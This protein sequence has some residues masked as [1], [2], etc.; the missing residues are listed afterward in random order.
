MEDIAPKLFENIKKEFESRFSGSSKIKELYKR[1]KSG[2]ATYKDAHEFAIETGKI[3]SFALKKN[4]RSSEL[5]DGRMYYN[6]ADR[7][8]RLMLKNNYELITEVSAIVQ[9]TLNKAANIGIKAIKPEFNTDRAQGIIDIVSGKDKYDD[10]AYMFDEPITNFSQSI[11]DDSVRTNADFQYR[12]GLSP[13]IIRTSTGKC[14]K[15]CDKLAGVYDYAD[16]SNTG[17]DVFRRH[18]HCR[19]LVEYDIGDGKVQNVYSKKWSREID[20]D[21]LEK[22]AATETP[23]NKEKRIAEENELDFV[24]RILIHPKILSTYSPEMLKKT[25]ENKGYDVKPLAGGS[26]KGVRFEDGGGFKVNFGGDGILQYHPEK[27]SHHEGEYY[28]ISTGKRGRK[29]YNIKGEEIDVNETR[30]SG[31]QIKKQIQIDSDK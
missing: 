26:L 2:N 5:P 28:K 24:S 18:K 27:G 19:C 7:I 11:V 4:I 6:I 17:S 9:E 30:K 23:K 12:A 25:L 31:K 22:K 14:C 8:I 21:I 3:L 1:I 15:W 10:I 13:K 16:V 29:W 20:Y